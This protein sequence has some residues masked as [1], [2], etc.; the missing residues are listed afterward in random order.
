MDT[1]CYD[2]IVN[3]YAALCGGLCT[4]KDKYTHTHM[5]NRDQMHKHTHTNAHVYNTLRIPS[6]ICMYSTCVSASDQWNGTVH[7]EYCQCTYMHP[8]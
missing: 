3:T 1:S 5:I 7:L 4:Y 6:Y 8:Q 2:T